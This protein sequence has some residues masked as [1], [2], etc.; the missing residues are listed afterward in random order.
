MNILQILPSLDI[1]GVETGTV[2]L[3]RHL[4]VNGHRAV[5]I[6]GGGRLVKELERANARHYTLPVGKKS[7]FN[8]V[9]MVNA[10]ASI[11]KQEDID[12][13]HARSRVPAIAAYF[14]C[15]LTNRIFITT[16]HGH[17]KKHLMSEVMGWGKYVI[18]AS[19]AMAKHM[20]GAFDVP[21]GRIRLIPRGVDLARFN[22]RDPHA[23]FSQKFTIGMVSRITPLKGHADFL[24]AV[25]MLKGRIPGLKVLIVGEAP[26]YKYREELERLSN[27]LGLAGIV[28]FTGSSDDIPEI[29]SKLDLLVSATVTPE[30][31]GRSIIEAQAS[32]VPVVATRVGGVVDIIEDEKNG[33]LCQPFAPRDMAGQISRIYVDKDLW[34]SIAIEGRKRVKEN[35]DLKLMMTRTLALYEEALKTQNILVIKMSA[36]GDVILSVPSLR[37]IKA[38][39]PDADIRVLIGREAR[40]VLD[41]CHYIND[42][43]VCD[44]KGKDRGFLGLWRLGRELRKHC[45]DMVIDLQNNRKSHMLSFLSFAPLRY[46]YDNRKLSVLL[47]RKVKDDAPYLD[48]VEHQARVLALAGIK[49]ED[50]TLELWPSESDDADVQK[51]L[52]DNWVKPGQELVGINIRASSRWESKN[53]P[54]GYIAELCDRLASEFNIRIVLTG[55]KSDTGLANKIT[56]LTRSKPVVAV[57]RTDILELASLI[58]R[59]K[60]YVTPD[61]AP[62]HIAA[63]VAVPFIALFGPTD[64]ARHLPPSKRFVLLYKTRELR[65]GPCYSPRCSK[66][67]KCM[68]K[69]SVDEVF[70]A[71]KKF[72]VK[73]DR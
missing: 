28:E 1:G 60:A 25:A 4:V 45:F 50:K 21:R 30:A 2:D 65:C 59:F 42:R 35:Y 26:K 10:I 32:G 56:K 3:A 29:M 46:G 64:P 39:Y 71:M 63:S 34:A 31:F 70:D 8:T 68:R 6:S 7:F 11:I 20:S 69:I 49:S 51:F 52:D 14:A 57:G 38:K 48:P 61:S 27:R 15:K 37:A 54:A 23:H 12:I 53:W 73:E 41:R 9:K 18:V 19:N 24:K 13:V 40:P 58:K 47:N 43:I 72:L 36:V 17:Y 16:A 66:N 5:V 44:F 22:F 67:F 62:M 55:L 33:L